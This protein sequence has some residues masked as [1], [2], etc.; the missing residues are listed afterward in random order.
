MPARQSVLIPPQR[1]PRRDLA[2]PSPGPR[3]R[4]RAAAV[5]VWY[6]RLVAALNV[7]AVMSLPFRQEVNEHNT[8][9]ITIH[10]EHAH[11]SGEFFTPYLATAGLVSA[12][13]AIFFVLV[14]QRRKRAA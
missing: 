11:H 2:L 8:G 9:R 13:L 6:L 4:A 14:M 10:R 7:V 3:L 12:A 1:S 5:T